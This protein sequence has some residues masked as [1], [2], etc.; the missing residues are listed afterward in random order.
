MSGRT[1]FNVS[2]NLAKRTYK[3]TVYDSEVE[4]KYYRDYI[5]PRIKNK[6]I[7][8]CEQQVPYLLQEGFKHKKSHG[9]CVTVRKIEY[10]ADFVIHWSN[11]TTQIVDTKGM[12]DSVALL[13]RKL[14]WYKY[15]ELDYIWISYCKKYGGWIEYDELKKLRSKNKR[16]K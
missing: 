3:G 9:K 2:K 10:V 13:K 16:S 8:S 5:E 7:L 1:K 12:P 14:F 15:P 4:M 6:E 11:G